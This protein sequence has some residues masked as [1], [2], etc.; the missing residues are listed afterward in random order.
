VAKAVLE[1]NQKGSLEYIPFPDKLQGSY[2][3]YTE[4]D[5][6]KLRNAGYSENFLDVSIGVKK[7]LDTLKN[8][9][10]NEY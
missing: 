9:P 5:I 4:A 2:Q 10:K 1:W 6:S 7:Y 3:S 8:W